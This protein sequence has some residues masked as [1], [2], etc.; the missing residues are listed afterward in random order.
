[1]IESRFD[2]CEANSEGVRYGYTLVP[3]TYRIGLV[4]RSV[5]LP[6]PFTLEVRT[7]PGGCPNGLG[8]A[9]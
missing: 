2:R 4:L 7:D 6:M 5:R 8:S 3:V 1:M 9:G